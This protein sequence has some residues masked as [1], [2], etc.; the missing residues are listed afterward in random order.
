[1][2]RIRLLSSNAPEVA[3]ILELLRGA[4]FQVEFDEKFRP[5][6]FRAWRQHPPFAFVIDL[7]RLPSQGREIAIAL[8]QSPRTRSVPILFVNGEADK[9]EA[10]RSVL[11][12]AVYCTTKDLIET[13]TTAK[14]LPDAITPA[15]MM[16]RYASRTAIQKLGIT[17]KSSI[18]L[19]DP[20]RNVTTVLG[21]LP[22]GAQF[23]EEDGDVTLYFA[24]SP[25]ELRAAM[26]DLRKLAAKTKL[27]IL[28]RKKSAPG[29]SGVTESLV[30][31]T[32]RD[33]GL[34]DY[35]ICSVDK[36]WSAML[37]ARKR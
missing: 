9:V 23:V 13:L 8:R 34:V 25:D 11:P 28:W 30:R 5:A 15:A 10:I 32:G 33:L 18:V 21:D 16:E 4:K 37:F 26:S 1:M 27:W 14:Q 19:I 17:E 2:R 3:T 36:T 22:R 24:T 6:L 31:E 20:P 29:H 35:K 7:S 12:D